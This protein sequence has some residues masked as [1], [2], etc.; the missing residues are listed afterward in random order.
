M[1]L[2]NGH[3]S[4]CRTGGAK[5]GDAFDLND[6]PMQVVQLTQIKKVGACPA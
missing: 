4:R 1:E 2:P 6:F 3:R 5:S